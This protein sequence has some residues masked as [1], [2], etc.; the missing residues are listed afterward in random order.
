MS[1]TH[2][3]GAL[4]FTGRR[5]L[6]IGGSRGVGAAVSIRLASLGAHVLI[7][8]SRDDHAAAATRQAII[9][10]AGSAELVKANVLNADEIRDA[11]G[12]I[13]GAPLDVL[14]HAAA[15]GSFKPTLDVKP[16][17]W[18]L[19]MGVSAR[20]LL[21]EAHAAAPYMPRGS[22]IVSLSSLGG[23]RVM[24]G[25]GAIGVAKAALESL[26]RYLACELAPNGIRVNTVA[27]GLIDGTSVA[28]HPAF[29]DV[30][31]ETLRR[32]PAGRLGR[33]SDVADAV[34]FLCSPLSSWIVGHTLVVDGGMSLML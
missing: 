33:S 24:P 1:L 34:V 18:D 12:R 19:T 31:D 26:T 29:V 22:C 10:S 3:S 21:I 4:D 8:Y 16:S 30:R 6:I 15:L 20:A 32:T 14:V 5:A 28:S 7:N 2:Q 27:A 23:A 13:G 9:A 25:Y 11:I 17:Q